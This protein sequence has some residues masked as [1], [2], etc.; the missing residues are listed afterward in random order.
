MNRF[1]QYA[2]LMVLACMLAVFIST[3]ADADPTVDDSSYRIEIEFSDPENAIKVGEEFETLITITNR[4]KEASPELNVIAVMGDG[5]THTRSSLNAICVKI[6]SLKPN[7]AQPIMIG[8]K[9][10]KAGKCSYSIEVKAGKDSVAKKTHRLKT[11]ARDAAITN[12]PAPVAKSKPGDAIRLYLNVQPKA[13]VG[14]EM[15]LTIEVANFGEKKLKQIDVTA[16]HDTKELKLVSLSEGYRL[17]K[18]GR[19]AGWTIDELPTRKI[20]VLKAIYVVLSPVE[21]TKLKVRVF[22]K[23]EVVESE[24]AK[25]RIIGETQVDEDN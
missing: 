2:C 16:G 8:L 17:E 24:K 6:G 9:A 25:V 4:G 13:S 7:D 20:Q 23:G 18:D 15:C 11:A 3:A 14:D 21:E 19:Q 1:T 5:L 10:T 12:E 22:Y